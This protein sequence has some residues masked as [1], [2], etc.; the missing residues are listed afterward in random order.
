MQTVDRAGFL[1]WIKS[2]IFHFEKGKGF[3]VPESAC[4]AAENALACGETIA[5]TQEG[6]IVSYLI[7]EKGCIKEVPGGNHV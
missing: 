3:V 6:K 5:L 1:E 4:I 7:P 2:N